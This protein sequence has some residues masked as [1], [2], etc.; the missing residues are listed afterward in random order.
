MAVGG[1]EMSLQFIHRFISPSPT[2]ISFSCLSLLLP[3]LKF[4]HCT[5][6]AVTV[7]VKANLKSLHTAFPMLMT[8][9][10]H[11]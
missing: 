1:E 9:K 5:I 8:I 10:R 3:F 7:N 2:H 4:C 6:R 11:I